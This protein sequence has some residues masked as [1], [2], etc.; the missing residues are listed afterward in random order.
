[1]VWIAYEFSSF[2]VGDPSSLARSGGVIS[3]IG[4]MVPRSF[5][6]EGNRSYPEFLAVTGGLWYPGY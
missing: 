4:C 3:G 2:Q 6:V 5:A 1:V